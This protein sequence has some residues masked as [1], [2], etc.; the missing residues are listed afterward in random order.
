MERKT[1]E[2]SRKRRHNQFHN[3]PFSLQK[4]NLKMLS[5]LACTKSFVNPS[6]F[7]SGI[8]VNVPRRQVFRTFAEESK[9]KT[10]SE[11]I[12][13]KMSLKERIMAPAGNDVISLISIYSL[14]K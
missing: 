5:R 10:R 8:Q 9:F 1:L 14:L 12:N 13:E 2:I 3:F 6:L 4:E 11:R 7:K